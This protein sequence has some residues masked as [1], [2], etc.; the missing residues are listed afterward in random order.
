VPIGVSA[1]RFS[2]RGEAPP[3]PS[4]GRRAGFGFRDRRSRRRRASREQG[5]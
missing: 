1:S 4:S 2:P 5:P 3:C